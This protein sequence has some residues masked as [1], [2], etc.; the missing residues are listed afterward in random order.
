[1]SLARLAVIA[2]APIFGQLPE[3]LKK[4]FD[5]AEWRIVRLLAT[6]F[7][8]F[9]VVGYF[10]QIDRRDCGRMGSQREEVDFY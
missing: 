6:A 10:E 5:E 8:E 3:D 4:T 9:P 2:F 7:P 1:M